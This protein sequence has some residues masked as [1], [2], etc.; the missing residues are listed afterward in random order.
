MLDALVGDTYTVTVTDN[1]G[2]IKSR[3]FTVANIECSNVVVYDVIT[4]NGDG[5]NDIWNI[6]GIRAYPNNVVMIFD[7]WGDMVFE[8]TNYKNT[9]DGTG[10]NGASLPDGTYYYLIKLNEPNKE[11]GANIF[12]GSLLIKR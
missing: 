12:K 10:T 11:G 4:P 3:S 2:C 5:K 9:W 7:K 8:Q 6:D 1:N